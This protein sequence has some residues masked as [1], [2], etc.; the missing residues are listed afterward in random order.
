MIYLI[1]KKLAL[2][3]KEWRRVRTGVYL[4]PVLICVI[5]W[6]IIAYIFDTFAYSWF[7]NLFF[8]IYIF[9][10]YVAL[11]RLVRATYSGNELDYTGPNS[12][13]FSII[14]R[15]PERAENLDIEDHEKLIRA[16]ARVDRLGNYSA[17]MCGLML[18]ALVFFGA[19]VPLLPSYLESGFNRILELLN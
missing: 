4:L 11:S 19:L 13:F 2:P 17:V 9:P 8:A 6:C 10:F 15:I 12:R 14:G 3:P 18:P 1:Q 5:L 7:G 16:T